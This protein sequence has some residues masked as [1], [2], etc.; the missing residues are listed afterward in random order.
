MF[1]CAMFCMSVVYRL[2]RLLF[3]SIGELNVFNYLLPFMIVLM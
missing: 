2:P 3:A 1:N